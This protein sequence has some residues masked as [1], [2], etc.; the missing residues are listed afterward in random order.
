MSFDRTYLHA[1][2][3]GVDDLAAAVFLGRNDMTIS[4]AC[5][6]VRKMDG[7]N[8]EARDL[9]FLTFGFHNWQIRALRRIGAGL[10]RLS[11][12]HCNRARL[13]DITRG[14]DAS[15]LL[16]HV[17]SPIAVLQRSPSP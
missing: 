15:V 3:I 10:E 9:V 12:G 14:S 5:D 4:T 17:T 13:A 2:A 7:G 11:P 16:S 8:R 6:L 1:V